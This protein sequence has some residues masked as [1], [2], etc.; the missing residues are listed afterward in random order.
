GTYQIEFLPTHSGKYLIDV[1]A[2]SQRTR[3]EFASDTTSSHA[4]LKSEMH[5]QEP[6][7]LLLQYSREPGTQVLLTVGAQRV[8]DGKEHHNRDPA[9]ENAPSKA[10]ISAPRGRL[11][12]PD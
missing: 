7:E 8:A 1:S 9:R 3:T 2:T 10:D 4:D 12:C 5:K 11:F 6:A